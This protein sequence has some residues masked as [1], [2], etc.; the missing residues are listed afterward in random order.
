MPRLTAKSC[1]HAAPEH[2][3][4]P[5]L[6]PCPY[7][8]IFGY[9][10]PLEIC[11][12]MLKTLPFNALRTL[13]AVVRLRGFG[14][15]ADELNIS[16]SA[17]SQHIKQLEDWLGHQLMIRKNPKVLPTDAGVRLAT[18]ARNGFGMVETVCDSLRDSKAAANK[19]LLVAAPPGFAFIWLLPRL[20]DFNDSHP[21]IQISLSTDPKSLDPGSSTAD[22]IIAYST[23]GFP[24]LH[25][26]K[27]MGE[28]MYPVCAPTLAEQIRTPRDLDRFTLLQ[29]GPPAEGHLSNWDFWASELGMK[30]PVPDK[31]QVY[32]QANMVIQAAINGSGVAMGRCPLVRDALQAGQ[33]VRPFPQDAES[34][35][36]YW[37]VCTHNKAQLKSTRQFRDWLHGKAAP[38]NE[39]PAP[40]H[41]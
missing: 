6:Q 12:F 11:L 13:E 37:F 36:S 8:A 33:L 32:S 19:G 1:N 40:V 41:L 16:Q 14:R 31:K 20:L 24:A 9:P 38:F 25:S 5:V 39:V 17:V 29:D 2:E 3:P 26:E 15:A 22:V 4:C 28:R 7:R 34:Q 23:G 18:A 30:V 21:S 35:F 10:T 27:L